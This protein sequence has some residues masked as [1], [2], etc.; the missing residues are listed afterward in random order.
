MIDIHYLMYNIKEMVF[1]EKAGSMSRG[2][3]ED[4]PALARVRKA[5]RV[6]KL[7]TTLGAI[8]LSGAALAIAAVPG[9]FDPIVHQTFPELGIQGPIVPAKRAGMIGLMALPMAVALFGLW[10]VRLLFGSYE[11]G[12][13]FT[14]AAARH[15]RLV[16]LAMAVNAVVS[17]L[18]HTLGSVLLTYDNA[19]GTRQLS[20][21][22][23]SDQYMLLLTG[24]LLIVIGWIMGEA[25]RLSDEH[26][27]I[28]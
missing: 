11:R 12:E 23:S 20:I 10:H 5:S 25:A 21:S 28:V 19:P 3:E 16:G 27:Q 8:G 24:G 18:V 2:A 9:W 14:G 17:L 4:F 22:L 7:M 6:L 1:Y 26:R 13:I 15:I